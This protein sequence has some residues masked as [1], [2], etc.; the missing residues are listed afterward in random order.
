MGIP[1]K[2]SKAILQKLEQ[3]GLI[4]GRDSKGISNSLDSN[5]NKNKNNFFKSK[6]ISFFKYFFYFSFFY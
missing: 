6:F 3:D 4:K 1:L 5:K 2:G